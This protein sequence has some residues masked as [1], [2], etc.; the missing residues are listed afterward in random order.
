[1]CHLILVYHFLFFHF[2][3]SYNFISFSITA[4]SYFS[5]CA[6]AND[7]SWDEIANWYFCSLKSIVLWL[8]VQNFLFDELLFLIWE[9][10]LIH[11][12]GKL[13][14]CFFSFAFLIFCL[15]VFVFD[16]CFRTGCF[17]FSTVTCSECLLGG[18]SLFLCSSWRSI[19]IMKNVT[20]FELTYYY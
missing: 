13:V 3:Y 2:L 7:F 14:P 11:L 1:M 16:V 15:G 12:F 5:K 6:S 20:I 8:F 9:L 18:R 10:H 17:F 4:N 19:W